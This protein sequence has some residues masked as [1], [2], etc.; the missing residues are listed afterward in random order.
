MTSLVAAGTQDRT[1]E[2]VPLQGH[3]NQVNW[4][5]PN[6][7][8][9]PFILEIERDFGSGKSVWNPSMVAVGTAGEIPQIKDVEFVC[10]LSDIEA[11]KK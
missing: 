7:W 2:N 8:F 9:A 4:S 5:L 3:N 6:P 1:T 10:S 11:P